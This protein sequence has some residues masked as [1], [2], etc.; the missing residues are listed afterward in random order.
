M[1]YL[2]NLPQIMI[3]FAI[4]KLKDSKDVIQELSKLDYLIMV[5]VFQ[6]LCSVDKGNIG[7][8]T[9]SEQAKRMN[10]L[11]KINITSRV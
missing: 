6:K 4:L 9:S 3:A 1:C 5:S 10:S 8:F 11:I 2:L 7:T